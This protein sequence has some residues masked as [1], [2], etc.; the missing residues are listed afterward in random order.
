MGLS[1]V[2][3]VLESRGAGLLFGVETLAF[4]LGG[5]AGG[6]SSEDPDEDDEDPDSEDELEDDDE[7]EED[8]LA[9]VDEAIEGGAVAVGDFKDCG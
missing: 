2:L 1:S 7:E 8:F 9:V 6:C 4:L 5:G 3:E